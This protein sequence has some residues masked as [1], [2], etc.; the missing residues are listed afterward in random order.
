MDGASAQLQEC[1]LHR[2]EEPPRN[3]RT[4]HIAVKRCIEIAC[5]SFGK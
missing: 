1:P 4:H 3:Q 2:K 5:S